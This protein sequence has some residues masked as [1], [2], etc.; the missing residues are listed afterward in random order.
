MNSHLRSQRGGALPKILLLIVFLALLVGF[1]TWKSQHGLTGK[2]EPLPGT[3]ADSIALIRQEGKQ[4][5]IVLVKA[6]GSGETSL[7]SDDKNK[8]SL[9]WSP[10]GRALCYSAEVSDEQGRANQLFIHDGAGSRQ[11]TQGSVSK[12]LP[13]WRPNGQQ[14]G[15]LTGGTVKIVRP[16]GDDME[17]IYPPPHKGGGGEEANQAD[18]Q[19]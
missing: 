10:D 17:Q 7:V 8:L 14:I 6:D 18:D 13:A 4:S 3:T 2:V 1:F 11:I 9:C 19:E 12:D 15:F 16:N 5:S